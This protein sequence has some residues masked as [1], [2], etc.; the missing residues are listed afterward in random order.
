MSFRLWLAPCCLAATL[1]A[2]AASR[3]CPVCNAPT[4]REVRAGLADDGAGIAAAAVVLPF[5]VLFGAAALVHF[6]FPSSR[7]RHGHDR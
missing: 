4:A 5:A 6:G 3:A 1:L 7:N 2:P